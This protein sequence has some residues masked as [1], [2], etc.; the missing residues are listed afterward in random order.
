MLTASR[1]QHVFQAPHTYPSC[2]TVLSVRS[3]CTRRE[4][5]VIKI[6]RLINFTFAPVNVPSEEG[7]SGSARLETPMGSLIDTIFKQKH[8]TFFT[9]ESL[10]KRS[11]GKS[12]MSIITIR[13]SCDGTM[14]NKFSGHSCLQSLSIVLNVLFEEYRRMNFPKLSES[15]P[16]KFPNP[17]YHLMYT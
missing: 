4:H 12:W 9:S 6:S 2:T 8:Q 16:S 17:C 14:E 1:P 5:M 11:D 13:R 7:W 15:G 3:Y 10:R